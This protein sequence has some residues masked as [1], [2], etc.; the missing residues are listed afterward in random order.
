[1]TDQKQPIRV[2]IVDD[3]SIV[4]SGLGAFLHAYKDMILVGEAK[5]GQHGV[6]LCGSLK[7]DVVLMDLVMPVMD[8]VQATRA[9][10]EKY[11]HIQVL[12]LTSFQDEKH[13]QDAIEAG[14]IGYLMK[15]LSADELAQAIRLAVEGKPTLSTEAAQALIHAAHAPRQLGDDLSERER[16]VLSFLVQGLS[17]AGIAEKMVISTGTVKFHVSSILSKLDVSSRTEAVVFALQHHLV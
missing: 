14:A 16:E 7:P 9:I 10:R 13:V 5:N 3:H 11:A 17:N 4:R 2:L 1:M 8:G 12:A 15:D 6:E